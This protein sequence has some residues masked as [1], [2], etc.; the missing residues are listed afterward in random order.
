M[1]DDCQSPVTE[2]MH[3]FGSNGV[4]SLS[5]NESLIHSDYDSAE[6]IAIA[7]SDLE[8][9]QLRKML[10]SPLYIQSGARPRVSGKPD[11]MFSFDSEPTLNTFLARNRGNEPGDQFKSS[12]HSVFRFA[13][14]SN[15]GGSILEGNKEHLLN[16]A[17]S[18][19]M[20]QEHHVGSLN[21]CIN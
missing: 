3:E 5:Y 4:K 19:L 8:D 20:K 14:P 15:V 7:D 2:D 10:A 1:G 18:E 13:G 21:S 11:A 6:G 16:Q 17:R 9:G 12:V